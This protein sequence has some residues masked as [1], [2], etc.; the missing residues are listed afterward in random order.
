M[1]LALPLNTAIARYTKRLQVKQM[2]IKD[3]RSRLMNELLS[4]IKRSADLSHSTC[5]RLVLIQPA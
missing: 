2:K 3:R 1:L 5:P 4:N